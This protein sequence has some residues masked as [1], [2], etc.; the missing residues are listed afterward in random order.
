VAVQ[1]TVG[2]ASDC[3]LLSWAQQLILVRGQYAAVTSRNMDYTEKYFVRCDMTE[4]FPFLVTKLSR[5]M[6]GDLRC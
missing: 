3:Q 6:T 5:A 4:E 1:A 2:L